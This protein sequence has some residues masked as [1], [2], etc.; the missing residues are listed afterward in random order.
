MRGAGG[1]PWKRLGVFGLVVP[2]EYG[3]APVST[4]AYVLITEQ[5]ARGW[6]SPA[7][8]MGGHTVVAK[9][10]LHR[11][12][13]RAD[14]AAPGPAHRRP[15]APRRRLPGRRHEDL[16]HQLPPLTADRGLLCKTDPRGHGGRHGEAVRLRDGQAD[17]PQRRTHPRRLRLLDRV[18]RR[19]L[20][21]GRAADDR[22]RGR[23]R[24][25]TEVHRGPVGEA[26][27]MDT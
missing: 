18:R 21:P 25:P 13:C 1:G 24:G 17:R 27:R 23:Q 4:P 11:W 22:R 3:G 20:L 7:D 26:R 5:L 19:T 9:L 6:M 14:G 15:R 2:E 16:D 8:T 10:L 12:L